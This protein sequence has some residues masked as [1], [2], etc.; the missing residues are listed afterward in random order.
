MHKLRQGVIRA[1][2][3]ER[4]YTLQEVLTVVVI[5]GVLAA[6]A[7]FIWLALLE[8]WRV[9]AA[10]E[11]IAADMRL[12]H[13]NAAN[14]LTDWRIVLAPETVDGD[15]DED[16]DPDYY[17]VRLKGVYDSG[18]PIPEIARSTPRTFPADVRVR[19]HNTSLN[20]TLGDAGWIPPA[21]PS[22]QPTR[23]LEFNPLGTM[24]FKQGPSGSVCVTVDGEPEIQVTA[25]SATSRVLVKSTDCSEVDDVSGN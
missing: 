1:W 11:Q 24:R 25:M 16:A 19:E 13:G 21:N 15:S 23:T 3:D 10:A 12:A 14:Q 5:V 17:L 7:V 4:G 8:R 9:E 22:P 6:I 2:R 18:D 20:D